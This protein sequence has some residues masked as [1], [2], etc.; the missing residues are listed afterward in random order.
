L[1]ETQVDSPYSYWFACR[2]RALELRAVR[3]LRDWLT[4]LFGTT[5]ERAAA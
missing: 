4:A 5:L 1:F 3:L 2:P